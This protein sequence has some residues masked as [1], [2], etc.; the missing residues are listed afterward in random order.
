MLSTVSLAVKAAIW[1]VVILMMASS[2]S[3]FVEALPYGSGSYGSCTYNTC[4][5]T[6]STTDTVV[7]STTPTA[8]GVY[9]IASDTIT[10]GTN[11][12]TGYTLTM[13]DTDTTTDLLNGTNVIVASSG[14]PVAPVVL[15]MNS[16]GWRI[17]SLAGFGAGPTTAQTNATS[18]GLTFAGVAAS[19]MSAHTLKT[20]AGPANPSQTT[21]VWYGVR[22]NTTKPSGTYT[23]QVTY[24]AVTND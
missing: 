9:T 13:K 4:G 5:I 14:T 19:N 22:I 12:S 8:S 7:L 15:A 3:G 16:W 17:D 6:I 10:V 11:A 24:T 23:N 20:T 21:N 1:L 2:T 18:N